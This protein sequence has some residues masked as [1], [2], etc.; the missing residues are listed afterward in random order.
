MTHLVGAEPVLTKCSH[1]FCG[2]C[3]EQWFA[4]NPGNKSWAKRLTANTV[5]CPV[6]NEG[7]LQ[8]KDLTKIELHGGNGS[9]FLYKML[10]ETKIV[11]ANN[12]K[13]STTG[14]CNWI[15]DYGSYQEHICA[16]KNLPIYAEAADSAEPAA[17]ESVEDETP[18]SAAASSDDIH[19]ENSFC[20]LADDA[21]TGSEGAPKAEEK[22]AAIVKE[23]VQLPATA[24][25]E[26][27]LGAEEVDR[28]DL[29]ASSDCEP[30]HESAC[31]LASVE[32]AAYQEQL[33]QYAKLQ[34]QWIKAQRKAA[35]Q[36][37]Q[38][39]PAE[40]LAALQ[41]QEQVAQF[42]AAQFQQYQAQCMQ[43]YMWQQQEQAMTGWQKPGAFGKR[44]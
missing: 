25:E 13:C 21:S 44:T 20:E 14:Q 28:Q 16:C 8:E 42:Q 37:E 6:C 4:A 39:S 40:K 32:A 11:C 41:W 31:D 1:L 35:E 36:W 17:T 12:A 15:G 23:H 26:Q 3:I 24:E 27:N 2:D 33:R 43:A 34:R 38:Q 5:P 19:S 7:L 18:V 22:N 10:S 29:A 9:H 30:V